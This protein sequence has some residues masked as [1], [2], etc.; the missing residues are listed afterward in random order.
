MLR[1]LIESHTV[2]LAYLGV[3]AF[4]WWVDYR[5]GLSLAVCLPVA[6]AVG[7]GAAQEP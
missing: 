4:G 3:S 1:W 6:F 7:Y 2:V 5:I